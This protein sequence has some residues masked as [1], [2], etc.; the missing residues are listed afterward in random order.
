M[1]GSR[2]SKPGGRRRRMSSPRLLTER[3]SQCQ[4]VGP[5]T[6]LRL[7]NPVMLLRLIATVPGPSK[8]PATQGGANSS[9]R[10]APQQERALA[11]LGIGSRRVGGRRAAAGGGLFRRGLR[12]SLG[13]GAHRPRLEHGPALRARLLRRW[14]RRSL[15]L[16]VLFD[17]A[18]FLHVGVVILERL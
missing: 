7:A 16:E 17:Q 4:A 6:P 2:P 1:R 3:S 9:P 14:L 12:L 10:A 13:F 5:A 18:P 8:E 11:P 15:G